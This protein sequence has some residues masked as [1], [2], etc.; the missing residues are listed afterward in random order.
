MLV[1]KFRLADL[2]P[3]EEPVRISEGRGDVVVEIPRA[4]YTDYAVQGLDEVHAEL[5]SSG[6]WFQLW[7]GEIVSLSSPPEPQHP[8]GAAR[9]AVGYPPRIKG[10]PGQAVRYVLDDEIPGGKP[11]RLEHARGRVTFCMTSK[12]FTRVGLEAGAIAAMQEAGQ[13]ML[14]GGQWIQ[15]WDGEIVTYYPGEEEAA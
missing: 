2:D 9:P 14:R 1:C 6:R 11:A 12:C 10:D 15:V 4:F 13:A 7:D 3:F 5:F 8:A